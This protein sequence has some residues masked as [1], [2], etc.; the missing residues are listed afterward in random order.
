MKGKEPDYNR[1][2]PQPKPEKKEKPKYAIRKVSEK[3][4][5]KKVED[6]E[7]AIRLQ[8]FGRDW[9]DSHPTKRCYECDERILVYTKM[10]GHH[11]IPKRDQDRYSVDITYNPKNMV[12]LCFADHSKCET[13]IDFAP[14]TK[15]LT[16]KTL[17]FFE[18][19]KL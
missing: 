4:K 6:K 11:I 1:F 10:N 16:Q 7:T 5:A 9:Y 18:Q 12:L 3:A 19:Y 2:N 13:N 8:Q 17:E 15:E 14:K